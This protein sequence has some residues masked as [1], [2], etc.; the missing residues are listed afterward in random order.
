MFG[1]RSTN[2]L[3]EEMEKIAPLIQKQRAGGQSIEANEKAKEDS[4]AEK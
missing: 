4:E 3:L 2:L 1:N